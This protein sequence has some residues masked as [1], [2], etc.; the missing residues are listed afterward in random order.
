MNKTWSYGYSANNCFAT[1]TNPLNGVRGFVTSEELDFDPGFVS[2]QEEIEDWP[3]NDDETY[4]S[5]TVSIVLL[6]NE[7]G[8]AVEFGMDADGRTTASRDSYG[9][10]TN[11]TYTSAFDRSAIVEKGG[12]ATQFTYDGN[13]NVLTVKDP[14]NNTQTYTYNSDNHMLTSKDPLN[15]TT[16]NTYDSNGNLLT[17]TDPTGVTTTYTYNSNGT[18]DTIND[19]ESNETEFGY[20]SYA[21]TTSITDPLN[22][23]TTY[24][25]SCCRVSSRTDARN[26]TTTYSYDDWGRRTGINYPTSTDQSFT[27]DAEGRMTQAV[28]GTGTRTYTYDSLGRK[29]YQTDPRGNTTATYDPASRLLSQTDVTGRLIEYDYDPNGRMELV[30]DPTSWA[31]YEYDT[32]GR[33]T[34]ESF[35]NGVYSAYGYDSASRLTSLNHKKTIDN[36]LI[37]GYAAT[38]DAASRLTQAV[39]SP[40]TATTTYAYDNANRLTS[41]D[42]TGANP[43]LSD[44]TYNSRGLRAT[45]FRSEDGTTSHD[46]TYTYDDAARLTQVVEEASGSAVNEY[47]TWYDDGLLKTYPGPGYD[48]LLDYDEE[49][50]MTKITQDYGSSQ[51]LAFEYGYGFDG[52][53]RWRKDHAQNEWN[54]YPCGVACSAGDLTILNNTIGGSTWSTQ[55]QILTGNSPASVSS[56]TPLKSITSSR[57]MAAAIDAVPSVVV[58]PVYDRYGVERADTTDIW[59]L[60]A[61]AAVGALLLSGCAGPRDDEESSKLPRERNIEPEVAC[62]MKRCSDYLT[63]DLAEQIRNSFLDCIRGA[64]TDGNKIRDCINS[65]GKKVSAKALSGLIKYASCMVGSD[66][67]GSTPGYDPCVENTNGSCYGCC[68][69]DYISCLSTASQMGITV[70]YR[71]L[72]RCQMDCDLR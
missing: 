31:T 65:F 50:Q 68:Y 4:P 70:C 38:Y 43:Y 34:K 30:E 20:D 51:T 60:L 28:D 6:V 66:L 22:H 32:R 12:Y 1:C 23:T 29:T 3:D 5:D 27:Y 14:L 64:G 40:T 59:V 55:F 41:D 19:E 54:W 37:L 58:Q 47:Y 69:M 61:A 62:K 39:E 18:V 9:Y 35:S 56:V 72:I 7:A 26:R 11:Y 44:Y 71:N 53:R 48:R 49:G 52:G 16:T 15:H 67:A 63:S 33:M 8:N 36:S 24:V 46:G 10:Q 25:Y 13:G 57:W 17:T 42:R 21:N 45:A 2:E